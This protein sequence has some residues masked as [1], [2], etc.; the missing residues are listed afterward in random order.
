M[1]FLASDPRG[2]IS[3]SVA[4][5]SRLLAS[6]VLFSR[7]EARLYWDAASGTL[8]AFSWVMPPFQA[9]DHPCYDNAK[10]ERFVKDFYETLRAGPNVREPQGRSV[11][12]PRRPVVPLSSASSSSAGVERA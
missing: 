7:C 5:A 10:G 6:F 1:R 12:S 2:C 9:C 4:L 11:P 3:L 8:P